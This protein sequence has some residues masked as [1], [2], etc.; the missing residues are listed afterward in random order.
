MLMTITSKTITKTLL[1]LQIILVM[2]VKHLSNFRI[3]CL[4]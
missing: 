1:Y 3:L 2:R 4:L